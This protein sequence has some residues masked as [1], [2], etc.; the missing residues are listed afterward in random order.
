MTFEEQIRQL[1][2]AVDT[3]YDAQAEWDSRDSE[4]HRIAEQI[5]GLEAAILSIGE[6]WEIHKAEAAQWRS[7]VAVCMC[8]G[9]R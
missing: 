5:E 6:L 4:Y 9:C 8:E 7:G 3:L 1:L 2:L